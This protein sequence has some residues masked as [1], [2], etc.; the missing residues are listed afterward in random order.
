MTNTPSWSSTN[1]SVLE[2]I[3]HEAR[4]FRENDRPFLAAFDLDST[5]YDLT[6]RIATIVAGFAAAPQQQQRFPEA[7]EQLKR[8]Q[9]LRTDWGI[10]DALARVGLRPEDHPHFYKELHDHWADCFFSDHYLHCDEPLPGAIE[11][12][13]ELVR[14]GAD[15]MYL[16]GRDIPR[17]EKGTLESLSKHGFPLSTPQ[18]QLVMKPSHRL[19]DAAFKVDVLKNSEQKYKKIW[20]FE[21][22]PVN[23]NAVAKTCPEIGLVFIESTHSGIEQVSSSLERISHFEVDLEEFRRFHRPL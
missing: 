4:D 5:L 17:M 13:Q 21:N 7:C 15:V 19:D 3:L 20:L 16:T 18:V 8:I 14:L 11:Y 10:R 9:I 6:L 2:Q 23:L 1:L 12:V 22:E